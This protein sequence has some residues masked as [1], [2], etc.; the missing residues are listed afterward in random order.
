MRTRRLITFSVLGAL[1]ASSIGVFGLP[2]NS[3]PELNTSP[4]VTQNIADQVQARP[5]TIFDPPKYSIDQADSIWVVVN[6]QR[7]LSPLRYRPSSLSFPNFPNPTTQN[8]YGLKLRTEAALAAESLAA[9]MLLANEGTLILNSGFRTFK[10]QRALYQ[11]TKAARGLKVAEKLSARPGHSEHQ[12]GLAADFSIQ[13]QGCSIMV[14]FGKSSGGKWLAANAHEFGFIIRYPKGFRSITGFQ[15][16][17]WHFRFV[18]VELAS[19]MKAKGIK[20][21]E[22]FWGLDPAPNYP[23]P[24]G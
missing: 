14:C 11:R 10:T 21:L 1:A 16:E 4:D 18:G 9:A 15:Y 19:E 2:K 8:P 24:A 13:G 17:P 12:L 23:N 7:P 6:K 22:Q 20:T 5:A 3:S